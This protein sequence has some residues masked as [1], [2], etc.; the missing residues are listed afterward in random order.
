MEKKE[1]LQRLIVRLPGSLYGYLKDEARRTCTPMA[2]LI[3]QALDKHF[4]NDRIVRDEKDG[5]S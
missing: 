1:T 3:R 2:V 5:V 4:G